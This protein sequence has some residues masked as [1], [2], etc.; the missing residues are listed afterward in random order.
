MLLDLIKLLPQDVDHGTV[1]LAVI[2]AVLGVGFWIAGV[3]FSRPLVTLVTV[4]GG[5]G[6]GMQMPRW[7]GWNVSGA[8]PAVGAAVVLGV[9]GFILHR[10]W[11]GLSLGLLL[12]TW[13]TLAIWL[14]MHGKTD[15]TWPA[16]DQSQP[17]CEYLKTLWQNVPSEVARLIPWAAGI[18]MIGALAAVILWPRLVT[19]VHWSALGLTLMT[20]L[21]LLTISHS[22]HR[23][24]LE[25]VPPRA[26]AQIGILFG[27]LLMGVAVQW[28]LSSSRGSAEPA[29]PRD[30]PQ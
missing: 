14:V 28:K 13:A 5:A 16:I 3:K 23:D 29:A 30:D 12:A 10:M 1:A 9:S 20:G 11:I 2:G 25:K 24:W 27:M 15:W 6:I 8:G 26:L 4:L 17:T 18:A 7:F 22:D 21:S 19:A